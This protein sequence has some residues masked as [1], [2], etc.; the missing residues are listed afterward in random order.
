[1][2]YCDTSASV[3]QWSSE[4]KIIPYVSPVDKKVHRY[5]PDFWVKVKKPD[6]DI[7]ELMIEIKPERYTKEPKVALTAKRKKPSK[8]YLREMETYAVNQA[9]W[10]SAERFCKKNNMKFLV[11][12]END[13]FGKGKK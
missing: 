11:M 5:Y 12:T 10:E 6:G 2:K 9:K 8:T 4:E 1:M 3:I 7:Q 13:I